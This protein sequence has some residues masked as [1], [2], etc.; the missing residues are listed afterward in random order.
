LTK[1]ERTHS[2][3]PQETI[4]RHA[5]NNM[6]TFDIE[7]WFHANYDNVNPDLSK[8]S[9]FRSNME[10]LLQICGETG[11][12]AT[13]FV[14]GCIGEDYPDV[15]RAIAREGHDVASHGYGHQLAYKQT[16]QEFK[17][18]VKKSVDILEDITGNKILGYRAPSWS[19]VESNLHYLEALE[20]LGLKYDASIF[21]IKTFLY[22]IPTAPT[23]IHKPHVN[24]REL[25]LYEVPMSVMKLSGR[26]IGY[27]GGF[28][29]R[30]F[31]NFFI[32]NAIRSANR[33]GKSSIVYLHPRE[34]DAKEQKL[35]LP[36]KEHFIHYYNVR[37]T[38]AKLEDILRS[39]NFTS[40][41]DHLKHKYA[42][43]V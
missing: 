2:G 25:N 12:K 21:P 28:Y 8:G 27:S 43:D 17:A 3:S 1:Q 31:P 22:G 29:F 23:E 5:I 11:C 41:S 14:L 36:Y 7:E 34:I 33:Q 40:I 10:T 39:F 18:D 20:E 19:I 32:K 30:F 35:S 37:S 38:K 15:V 42:L 13:F 26:N 16:I 4:N 6:L 24:G 9:N